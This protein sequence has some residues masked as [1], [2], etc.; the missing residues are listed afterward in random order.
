MTLEE[1]TSKKSQQASIIVV[2]A[3]LRNTA[4]LKHH[5]LLACKVQYLTVYKL[6]SNP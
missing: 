3:Q 2:K 5:A 4:I 6:E 1:I